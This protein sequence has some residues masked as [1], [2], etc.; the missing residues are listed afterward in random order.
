MTD[1][2][3]DLNQ[4]RDRRDDQGDA[5]SRP[6][7]MPMGAPERDQSDRPPARWAAAGAAGSG[8][9]ER[10]AGVTGGVWVHEAEVRQ[11][12]RAAVPR[13]SE[14]DPLRSRRC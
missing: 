1:A 5:P 13:M 11:K 2:P 7:C 12:R 8:L 14:T 10:P 4:D 9:S 6:P 3:Y